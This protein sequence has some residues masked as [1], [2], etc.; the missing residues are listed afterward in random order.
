MLKFYV[1]YEWHPWG[2]RLDW[3]SMLIEKVQ[4]K[5][6][7][8]FKELELKYT[9]DKNFFNDVLSTNNREEISLFK[10]WIT[11][12]SYLIKGFKNKESIK[13][14]FDQLIDWNIEFSTK[15]V[16]WRMRYVSE[17]EQEISRHWWSIYKLDF[18]KDPII[19]KMQFIDIFYYISG[20]ELL[21]SVKELLKKSFDLLK[22]SD[23]SVT[24]YKIYAHF[25]QQWVYYYFLNSETTSLEGILKFRDFID[26]IKIENKYK[27]YFKQNFLNQLLFRFID[28][29]KD[30]KEVWKLL[31][32][33]SKSISSKD[34]KIQ[35]LED[36]KDKITDRLISWIHI[37]K[38]IES[39]KILL[40]EW[41][42]DVYH[43]Q[44]AIE[45]LW[46]EEKYSDLLILPYW[47]KNNIKHLILEEEIGYLESIYPNK[48][49]IWLMD[50]DAFSK[51]ISGTGTDKNCTS[52]FWKNKKN[53]LTRKRIDNKISHFYACL[54]PVPENDIKKQ[55]FINWIDESDGCFWEKSK[56]TIEHYFYWINDDLDNEI[57]NPDAI[58]TQGKNFISYKWSKTYIT[59]QVK[60]Y[61]NAYSNFQIIFEL[62]D[63]IIE[64]S[65][66]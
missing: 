41:V 20:Y 52:V 22:E 59:E 49:V 65:W 25:I 58:D 42:T 1:S 9:L 39:N 14:R 12:N 32:E 53:G 31:L 8:Y 2:T 18:Y 6:E 46:L 4:F 48:L 33:F 34:K 27:L 37:Q 29:I 13:W 57:F 64:D 7:K 15:D 62:I 63:K 23:E 54:L 30:S 45:Y 36:E 28:E 43:I 35:V 51:K 50:Y 56:L 38:V 10:I 3:L 17:I 16:E 55:V 11:A 44:N 24:E 60:K 66:T 5:D 40:V 21:N 47:W 19:S 61:P 26:E